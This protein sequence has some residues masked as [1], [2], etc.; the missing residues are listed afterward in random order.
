MTFNP[1]DKTNA[2]RLEAVDLLKAV[3]SAN[4][5]IDSVLPGRTAPNADELPA[6]IIYLSEPDIK[7]AMDED[8]SSIRLVLEIVTFVEASK[9]HPDET[10]DKRGKL[11]WETFN[12]A[13]LVSAKDKLLGRGFEYD[14]DPDT[15]LC[16][17]TI[18]FNFTL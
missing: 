6:S 14:T 2:A 5:F 1:F 7:R 3:Y 11:I 13:K 12:Q 18:T 10:L 15:N 8:D 9:L 16:S 17:L 4:G